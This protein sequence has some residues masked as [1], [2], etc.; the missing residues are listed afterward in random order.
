MLR[1]AARPSRERSECHGQVQALDILARSLVR[2]QILPP[3]EF[4]LAS[5]SGRLDRGKL[6]THWNLPNLGYF[7][8]I[9]ASGDGRGYHKFRKQLGG[10]IRSG[11]QN[12]DIPLRFVS[13]WLCACL[14]CP[15]AAW[16]CRAGAPA[17]APPP[18][19][20]RAAG[21]GPPASSASRLRRKGDR[22]SR[23][24]LQ[25][26]VFARSSASLY[27]VASSR[28]ASNSTR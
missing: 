1:P 21:R 20:S 13:P 8:G 17:A 22:A 19:A 3:T 18:C 6:F 23:L 10:E 27:P 15:A 2:L 9:I 11:D 12:S 16:P 28:C 14:P 25:G 26:K 24:N 5:L 7:L 4:W